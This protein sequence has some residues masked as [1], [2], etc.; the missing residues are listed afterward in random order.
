MRSC[1][2]NVYEEGKKQLHQFTIFCCCQVHK[3]FTVESPDKRSFLMTKALG[4]VGI[5]DPSVPALA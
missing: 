3:R 4:S 5:M 2:R 1:I